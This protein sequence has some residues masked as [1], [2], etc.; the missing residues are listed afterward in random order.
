MST[1]NEQIA[2][3][4]QKLE[5]LQQAGADPFAVHRFDRSHSSASIV[6]QI[7]AIEALG[8]ENVNYVLSGVWWSAQLAAKPGPS[9]AFTEASTSPL[10][11]SPLCAK[12]SSVSTTSAPTS[13][14]SATPKPREVAAG[15]PRRMPEV[16]IGFS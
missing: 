14:N 3:R 9:R 11:A 15:V 8:Q 5:A 7:E 10:P 6:A 12:P 1:D 13:R 2:I 16:T 4:R